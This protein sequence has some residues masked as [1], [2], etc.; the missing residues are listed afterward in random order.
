VQGIADACAAIV[1]FLIA[2][3]L[4][5][6]GIAVIAGLL[7]SLS[8]HLAYYTLFL[9]PDTLAVLPILL[10]VYF[11][12]RAIKRPR[13]IHVI[14][15]G[16]MI[17]LS[18]W[19]RSNALLLAPFMALAVVWQFER[20]KRLRY[21]LAM[22]AAMMMTV[23]PVTVRNAVVFHRFIPLS[24]GAGVTLIEGIAEYDREGRF[25]LPRKDAEV[26]E[27]EAASY[28]RPD[29]AMDL[30]EPD[31]IERER[32]RVRRG[33]AVIRAHPVWYAGVMLRRGRAMLRY[34]DFRAR[35]VE[36]ETNAPTLSRR[37]G[38]G[39]RLEDADGRA[40]VWSASA[41]DLLANASTRPS[42]A[43]LS[44]AGNA[45]EIS[46]DHSAYACQ[47]AS[48][49]V[50]VQRHTDYVLRLALRLEQGQMD[51]KVEAADSRVVLAVAPA[52]QARKNKPKADA[53]DDADAT[54]IQEPPLR[55]L[56]VPF[57]SGDNTEVRLAFYNDAAGGAV[58]TVGRAEMFEVGATPQQ[59][60]NVPRALIGGVQK[61][62][63]KTDVM[64]LLIA[65]GIVCLTLAR[66]GR[67]L[68]ILLM[69]PAYYLCVQSALHTEYRY[70]LGIHYFLFILAAVALYTAGSLIR[71]GVRQA[72]KRS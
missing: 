22:I 26:L 39:H 24:L 65:A 29:Y 59:W 58:L 5:P 10:A 21:G 34:N 4:F 18:C 13:L 49:L 33:L 36:F 6:L 51:V 57:A 52:A 17:G 1:V 48:P 31:G 23:L 2:A 28:G 11:I 14:A 55:V 69:V 9:S 19:L 54:A 3:E 45:L 7:V 40:A 37:P 15:A 38:F 30:Y 70:T 16:L 12:I 63:F 56:E 43:Q 66:R 46:G 47:L 27:S 41:S 35:D 71:Q 62:L 32:E 67:A 64:R 8:P 61:N 60:T 20:G 44:P 42:Q 53:E 72:V 68:A 25:A 50:A